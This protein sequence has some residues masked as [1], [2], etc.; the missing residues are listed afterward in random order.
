MKISLLICIDINNSCYHSQAVFYI[1]I[2][3][4]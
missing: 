3:R 4:N 2:A 1:E